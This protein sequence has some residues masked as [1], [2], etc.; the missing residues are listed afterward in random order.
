[1][2]HEV[3]SMAWA[4]EVPWHGLGNKVEGSVTVDDML[5]AAGLNWNVN[6]HE[7]WAEINGQ[8]IA[9]GRKA[10]VRD[11]DGKVLSVT[12]EN[13]K[14][15]QNK[16]ALGFFR[17]YTEAGGATLE[18][19]GSL[20]GGKVVWGLARV[21]TGF[22]INGNDHVKGYILLVSPHEVGQAITVR[23]T[24]VRVVCANTLA[25]AGGV[26]GANA[27]YRQSH[28]K[29]FDTAAAKATVELVKNQI[30]DMKLE[31]EALSQLKMSE[32]DTVR[33]LARFFQ[34]MTKEEIAVGNEDARTQ[35]LIDKPE[36]VNT[37]LQGVLWATKKAPGSTAGNGW[38]VLNGVTYW[39]DHMVGRSPDARLYNSWLGDKGRQKVAV[40]QALME[41]V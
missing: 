38:G 18:T 32:F 29:N 41:M 9:V 5:V 31:A 4:H 35:M 2:A 13:W 39:A 10:L 15:F 21:A 33:F 12:G 11:T 1:M 37:D 6:Q 17:E 30:A 8:K 40:K 27:E 19:A 7:C 36:V 20:K 26:K 23:T 34:P 14:P 28:V 24:S 16:D 22:T 25:M 3:E